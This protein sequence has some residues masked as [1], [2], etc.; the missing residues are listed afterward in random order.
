LERAPELAFDLESVDQALEW[1]YGWELGPVRQMDA[2]GLDRI[3]VQMKSLGL[4]EPALLEQAGTAFRWVKDG[5]VHTISLDGGTEAVQDR[6]PPRLTAASLHRAGAVVFGSDHAALLDMGEGGLLFE[7]R[8]R[9][10]TLGAEVVDAL[11]GA[12]DRIEEEG[13]AGLVI[14]NDDAR[15]FSAGANLKAVAVAA[16]AGEW[17]VLEENIR[18][19]QDTSMRLRGAPFPVVAAPFGLTLGGGCE[20][21][22]HC[23]AVQAH[24]ELYM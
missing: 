15:T 8:S 5:E 22:L 12:L 18:A 21:S 19:F 6:H 7:T 23:D 2:I 9:M 13:Y 10:N 3:R 14:G 16:E 11:H 20:F 24:A 1:G 4:E 17:K